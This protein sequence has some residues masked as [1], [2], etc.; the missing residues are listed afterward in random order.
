MITVHLFL[1]FSP[2]DL[3]PVDALAFHASFCVD[4][5]IGRSHHL[6]NGLLLSQK[7]AVVGEW[8]VTTKVG[9]LAVVVQRVRVA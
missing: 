1:T 4:P 8:K 6:K 2:F 3:G 9:G 7:G 5:C